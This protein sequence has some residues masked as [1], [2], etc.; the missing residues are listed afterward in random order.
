MKTESPPRPRRPPAAHVLVG[1]ADGHHVAAVVLEVAG[2]VQLGDVAGADDA[3]SN[4][5]LLA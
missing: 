4:T 1:V 3:Q 5:I 2:H